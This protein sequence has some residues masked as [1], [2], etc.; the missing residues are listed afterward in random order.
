MKLGMILWSMIYAP[1]NTDPHH[2]SLLC[3]R[4][5]EPRRQCNQYGITA[6]RTISIHVT[7]IALVGSLYKYVCH[8]QQHFEPT[9]TKSSHSLH[10][11]GYKLT[12]TVSL[13]FVEIVL[14]P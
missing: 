8:H 3:Q 4:L 7:S 14:M 13:R 2:Q 6:K 1:V 12:D 9:M 5:Y 11:E 10:C